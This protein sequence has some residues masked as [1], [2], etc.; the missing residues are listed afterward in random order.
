MAGKVVEPRQTAGSS[1][2]QF[3][4]KIEMHVK[5]NASVNDI[6]VLL[7]CYAA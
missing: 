2:E 7:E 3:K 6:C 4:I 1:P 5:R